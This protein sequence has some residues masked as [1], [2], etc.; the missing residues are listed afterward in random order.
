[1]VELT[2]NEGIIEVKDQLKEYVNCGARLADYCLLDFFLNTYEANIL[3][4][5]AS[6]LGRPSNE[7]VPYLEGTGHGNKSRVI[8]SAGPETMPNFIGEWFPRSDVPELQEYYHASMLALLTPWMNIGQL[9]HNDQTFQEAFESFLST[10]DT[11]TLDI[12]DNIQYHYEC[13]DSALRKK[14]E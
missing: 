9:K 1:M 13:A 5:S 12:I 8:R 6:G 11:H 14:Q 10:A 3:K 4:P 7:R 2:V